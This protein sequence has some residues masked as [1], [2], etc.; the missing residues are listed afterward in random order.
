MCIQ[1]CFEFR[2]HQGFNELGKV[3]GSEGL[4]RAGLTLS[5]CRDLLAGPLAAA[6]METKLRRCQLVSPV[7]QGQRGLLTETILTMLVGLN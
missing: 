1:I 4:E 3:V 7:H 2:C 5:L 6:V